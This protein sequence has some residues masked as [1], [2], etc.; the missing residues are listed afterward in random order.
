MHAYQARLGVPVPDAT[1]WDQIEHVGNG[2]YRVFRQM[3]QVAAQ[4]TLMFHDDTAVRIL[5]LMQEHRDRLAAAQAPGM[6]T[7]P[8]RLG[9]HTTALVGQVGEH[10]ARL[11][12]SSRRQAGEN[13]QGLLDKREAGLAK[14]LAMSEALSRNA[15]ADDGAVLRCHC[16]AHG[17]RQFSD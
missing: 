4:G 16:L 7:P 9:M 2:A 14:P 11:D 10:T 8:E 15:V 13:L 5:A 12:D 17:R 6:A 3:E 1:Q